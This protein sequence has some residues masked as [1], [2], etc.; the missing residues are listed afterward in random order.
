MNDHDALKAF[1]RQIQK[2]INRQNLTRA[3]SYAMFRQLLDNEQPDL[4]QGAFLAAL[5]AK[6]ETPQEIAGAWQAI[7]ELDTIQTQ[8][9]L[10]TPLVENSGTGMD[11]LKTFNVSSAAAVVAAAWRAMGRG[12]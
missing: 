10:G 11:A 8:A 4:Q 12:P 9:D 1:G 7:F 5:A 6:G 2:L 3:E